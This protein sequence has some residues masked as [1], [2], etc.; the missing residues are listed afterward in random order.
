MMITH[1]FV[2]LH[3]GNRI[4]TNISMLY[5]F[6]NR[7]RE[8]HYWTNSASI[9]TFLFLRNLTHFDFFSFGRHEFKYIR[10]NTYRK[11]RTLFTRIFTRHINTTRL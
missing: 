2:L 6:R 4:K 10:S 9:I 5:I 11:Q 8:V 3:D 1:L 7:T